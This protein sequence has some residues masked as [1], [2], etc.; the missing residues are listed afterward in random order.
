MDRMLDAM[1]AQVGPATPG[2]TTDFIACRRGSVGAAGVNTAGVLWRT[3]S[4]ENRSDQVW[5]A[6]RAGHAAAFRESGASGRHRFIGKPG[7]PGAA[8]LL[9]PWTQQAPVG[10]SRKLIAGTRLCPPARIFPSSP[11]VARRSSASSTVWGATYLNE[12]GFISDK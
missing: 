2:A 5:P 4:S 6:S 3:P 11:C 8:G 12:T 9:A 1:G 7:K 10:A